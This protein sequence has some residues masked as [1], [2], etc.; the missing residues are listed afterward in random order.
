MVLH[1]PVNVFIGIIVIVVG[2][3]VSRKGVFIRAR[4]S[5]VGVVRRNRASAVW[6]TPDMGN[7][8][9]VS[10][11]SPS[12]AEPAKLPLV[13]LTGVVANLVTDFALHSGSLILGA[14]GLDVATV[15]T[16][17]TEGVHVKDGG[18]GWTSGR[19]DRGSG[20]DSG[21]GVKGRG[22]GGSGVD[23]GGG[24]KEGRAY[25]ALCCGVVC[26]FADGTGERSPTL[27]LTFVPAVGF[28][29]SASSVRR[30]RDGLRSRRAWV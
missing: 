4:T 7:G 2:A 17:G 30:N 5:R 6:A 11:V 1:F 28:A 26:L 13:T 16:H 15:S 24:V 21:A 18:G 12:V 9:L 14:L 29:L 27:P 10:L 8:A 19:G 22:S 23:S 20:A 3:P 25:H